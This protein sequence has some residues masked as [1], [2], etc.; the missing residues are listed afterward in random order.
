MAFDGELKRAIASRGG[1]EALCALLMRGATSEKPS[2][3]GHAAA[4]TLGTI[5]WGDADN[6]KAICDR[7]VLPELARLVT[8]TDHVHGA[9]FCLR[10]VAAGPKEMKKVLEAGAIPPL[11]A[12][13][14]RDGPHREDAAFALK[15]L[16][17]D[18]DALR[19]IAKRDGRADICAETESRP[20]RGYSGDGVA[21]T[22]RLRRG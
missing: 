7:G 11:A 10:H 22:P 4:A 16:A 9:C 3:W 19:A 17:S 13:L 12:A 2:R 6:K 8:T 14:R 18:K 15:E 21:A 20:R 1:V 5:A